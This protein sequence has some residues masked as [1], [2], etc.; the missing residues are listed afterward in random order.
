[1]SGVFSRAERARSRSSLV[2]A[3]GLLGAVLLG[4]CDP[5]DDFF[6]GRPSAMAQAHNAA[7]DGSID[8]MRAIL[9]IPARF[10]QAGEQHHA[11]WQESPIAWWLAPGGRQRTE[12]ALTRLD[13]RQLDALTRWLASPEPY[14]DNKRRAIAELRA[15]VAAARRDVAVRFSAPAAGARP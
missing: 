13:A 10:P 3:G 12:A 11:S 7:L 1:M 14:G 9:E 4:G 6:S 15:A 5:A 2:I 8:T